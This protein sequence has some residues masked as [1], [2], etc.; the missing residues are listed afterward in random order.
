MVQYLP[1]SK[2]TLRDSL[3]ADKAG[4]I[5]VLDLELTA[6]CSAASC[7]YCDSMPEVCAKPAFEGLSEEFILAT[8]EKTRE[9][10]LKWIYTCG[11]GEPL[12]DRRF[13]AILGFMKEFGI[14]MSIFSN[15]LFINSL[16]V[17]K[18]LKSSNVNIILKMDTFDA[19]K[20]D[21]ILGG[22][23]GRAKK[24]YRAID[25]L[26]NAGYT[27][28]GCEGYTDLAFSIV[29]TTISKDTIPE[30]VE[31]CLKNN[32]FPSVGELEKAGNVNTHNLFDSLGLSED[33]LRRVKK[34]A[35]LAEMNYV[36]PVCPAILTGLHIDNQGNCVVDEVTGLN[37]K[38]FLLSDPRI[39]V[40][41]NVAEQ[42]ITELYGMVK[43]YR[44]DCWEQ[45]KGAIDGYEKINYVF[46]GC[47]G[48]PSE[49]IGLYKETH[50]II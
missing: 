2:E 19:E 43:K 50:D 4:R 32:I 42:S 26:L 14:K 1:W 28:T 47:G 21:S 36:R 29:P 3:E 24:I 33:C 20:F 11:L 34:N 48:N 15:G 49:I 40:I 23:A 37:C 27:K 45:N 41:G 8:L 5:P 10:G 25:F 12:E 6:R 44:V 16:K 38:W 22:V 46:G 30:V 31:F 9:C 18:H 13:R 17:A 39:K 35:E 7:I